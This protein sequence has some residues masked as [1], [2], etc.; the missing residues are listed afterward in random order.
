MCAAFAFRLVCL[1]AVTLALNLV[2][3]Q[4]HAADLGELHRMFGVGLGEPA[5]PPVHL[6]S[7]ATRTAC[8]CPD[9]CT[10][11]LP[12]LGSQGAMSVRWQLRGGVCRADLMTVESNPLRLGQEGVVEASTDLFGLSPEQIIARYGP[13]RIRSDIAGGQLIYCGLTS[14]YTREGGP[15]IADDLIFT[16]FLFDTG[17]L[18]AIRV[19]MTGNC[20]TNA[21]LP[22]G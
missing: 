18:H 16:G 13:P 14:D 6:R 4:A 20:P 8:A 11:D 10:A 2:C 15:A 21:F 7:I 22:A 9:F 12:V 19:G 17:R 1:C 3:A 5:N